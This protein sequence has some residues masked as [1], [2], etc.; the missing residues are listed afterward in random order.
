MTHTHTHTHIFP[1]ASN[2]LLYLRALSPVLRRPPFADDEV[3]GEA[4]GEEL[5]DEDEHAGKVPPEGA[6][7]LA[8]W[9]A[10]GGGGDLDRLG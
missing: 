1:L 8:L 2:A 9:A 6:P 7:T 5:P 4:Q 10:A 3:E